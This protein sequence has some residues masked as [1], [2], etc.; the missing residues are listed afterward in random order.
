MDDDSSSFLSDDELL[1]NYQELLAHID[2]YREHDNYDNFVK[3]VFI[4]S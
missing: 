1:L 3:L 2:T 4:S